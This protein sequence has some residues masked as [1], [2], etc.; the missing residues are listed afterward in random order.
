MERQPTG[1]EE[2]VCLQTKK[3]R[4]TIKG[5]RAHLKSGEVTSCLKVVCGD[6]FEAELWKVLDV[7]TG[8]TP[9]GRPRLTYTVPPLFAL[10]QP[11]EL[12]AEAVGDSQ[13][14]F[15]HDDPE[16]QASITPVG[17]DGR[18]LSGILRFG[19][20]P[21]WSELIFRVDGQDYLCLTLEVFPTRLSYRQDYPT[22]M[23][24]V[25]R[26][27]YGL[28]FDFWG[29][30][31]GKFALDREKTGGPG[32]FFAVLRQ[33]YRELIQAV[34]RILANPHHCL[35][36]TY[37]VLP[38]HR[39]RQP[40][41]RSLG[42][43]QAHPSQVRRGDAGWEARRALAACK[44]ITWDT[45]ENRF[46]AWVLRSTLRRLEE[47]KG[48]LGRAWGREA[49][50]LTRELEDMIRQLRR[51]LDTTFL[52]HVT[53]TPGEVRASL[54]LSMAPGYRELYRYHR[55]LCRGLTLDC[56]IFRL[57]LKELPILYEYWCFF[58]LSRLLRERFD[59]VT[60]DVVQVREN[61]LYLS[62]AE[63]MTLQYRN[64]KTGSR[65]E[66]TYGV[67]LP[68]ISDL[69]LIRLW[70]G[71]P[72]ESRTCLFS[73]SYHPDPSGTGP[74]PGEVNALHRCRDDFLNAGEGNIRC[75]VLFPYEEEAAY[76]CHRFCR[77]LESLKVGGLPFLPP[78][79]EL[80]E[81]LLDALVTD[82]PGL[83]PPSL[84]EEVEQALAQVDWNRWDVLVGGLRNRAQLGICLGHRFYHIP[85][86]ALPR[87]GLSIRCVAIYQ[88]ATI[89]GTESGIRYYGE[90]VDCTPVRRRQIR[91]IPKNSD[92]WYYRFEIRRW[93]RLPK[94]IA[95]KEL[96][97]THL[98][99]NWFLLMNST[100]VPELKLKSETEYRLYMAI[101]DAV[102]RS[103]TGE[104]GFVTGN[105]TVLCREGRLLVCRGK[106][107]V[108]DHAI[109]DYRNAPDAVFR[110][111]MPLLEGERI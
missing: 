91:E 109:E 19:S 29:R 104:T 99:T 46:T 62:L 55:M 100:Q 48:S 88:S 41:R 59:L 53:G 86:A 68:E 27:V 26:E 75:C 17:R 18:L 47:L 76:R 102:S 22:L 103:D 60:R 37:Q 84:P 43:M 44:Q 35:Q 98:L 2:L 52:A 10:E 89:F 63:G 33:I 70:V 28:I 16:L 23:Q 54:V 57:S 14:S 105:A 38:G 61:G 87:D 6:P 40:D 51:R 25:S 24:D 65:A 9:G 77:S 67:R 78:A 74:D 90:V 71:G 42:W 50:A 11:Y 81:E 5:S 97:L 72:G 82:V 7:Q 4:V 31:Y 95:V 107:I 85:A 49:I 1:S 108:A 79:T 13:I 69:R 15:C 106:Q 21:G 80:V 101:K 93:N 66:L 73:V 96:P 36:T 83:Q 92:E 45:P 94:P 111:L 8:L 20:A 58:R 3:I 12:L 34:D 64:P 32:E 30:T 56:D 39:L 110:S